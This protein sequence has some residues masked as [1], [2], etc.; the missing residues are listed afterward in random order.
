MG[1]DSRHQRKALIADLADA[2]VALPG[3]IGTLDELIEIWCWAKI[4]DHDKACI[5]YDV[6]HF[7]QPFFD[8]LL[9]IDNQGF[10]HP[11]SAMLR[12]DSPQQL[13]TELTHFVR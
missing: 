2:F 1:V 13:L 10:A 8:L 12:T 3:G 5:C 4:G 6:D 7:W 11:G 9:H